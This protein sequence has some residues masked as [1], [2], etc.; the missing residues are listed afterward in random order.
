[1][2]ETW[3]L[4]TKPYKVLVSIVIFRLLLCGFFLLSVQTLRGSLVCFCIFFFCRSV[5]K[6]T[7][8]NSAYHQRVSLS[9]EKQYFLR[10]CRTSRTLLRP[11]FFFLIL[12]NWKTSLDQRS[13]ITGKISCTAFCTVSGNEL[14]QSGAPL[15]WDPST[16]WINQLLPPAFINGPEQSDGLQ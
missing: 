4:C 15:L 1:M 11:L 3:Q 5:L 16:W 12:G 9:R 14:L 6:L 13:P 2:L 10:H 8:G 7:W